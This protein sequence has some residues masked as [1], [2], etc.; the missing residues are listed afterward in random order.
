MPY[1]G[2]ERRRSPRL[3]IC[4]SASLRER[5]R[6]AFSVKLVDLSPRGCRVEL[7]SDLPSGVWV[8]LKLP[9]LEPRYSRIAWSRGGFAGIEFEA[10]LHEA[11]FDVLVGIDREPSEAELEE[12]RRISARCRA[13]AE[14]LGEDE[15]EELT[16]A[17]LLALAGDCD[18]KAAA[19]STTG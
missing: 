14:G 16:A 10:P 15:E 13:L 5:G 11:V 18:S 9:G 1:S 7:Y 8:W 6:S 17:G 3:A 12:L 2:P 19:A 4:L